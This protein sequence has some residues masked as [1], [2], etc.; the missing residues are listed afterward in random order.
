M[1]QILHHQYTCP[2]CKPRIPTY[3]ALADVESL[4]LSAIALPEPPAPVTESPVP[5]E[6]TLLNYLDAMPNCRVQKAFASW[7]R[8]EHLSFKNAVRALMRSDP[9]A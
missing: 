7:L 9:W 1:D 4:N 6:V 8:M 2:T 5:E 3:P